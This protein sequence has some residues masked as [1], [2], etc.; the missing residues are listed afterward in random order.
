MFCFLIA[1]FYNLVLVPVG[2]WRV[3]RRRFCIFSDFSYLLLVGLFQEIIRT[4]DM[5]EAERRKVMAKSMPQYDYLEAESI[6]CI[7]V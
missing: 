2:F 5:E 4:G 3:I 6:W 7:M 1:D